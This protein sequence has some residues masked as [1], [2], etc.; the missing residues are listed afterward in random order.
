MI[1]PSSLS[2]DYRTNYTPGVR[3]WVRTT[4][5]SWTRFGIRLR[6]RPTLKFLNWT[7][8]VE[9]WTL[10]V[11]FYF[12]LRDIPCSNE[13]PDQSA[14]GVFCSGGAAHGA[15]D[16]DATPK[17][18]R[19]GRG[20]WRGRHGEH[21]RRAN[22]ERVGEFHDLAGWH[23]LRPHVWVVGFVC[24]SG[25]RRGERVPAR[26][27]ETASCSSYLSRRGNTS[28]FARFFSSEFANSGVSCFFSGAS[29]ATNSDAVKPA[30]AKANKKDGCPVV[31][32]SRGSLE[33]AAPGGLAEK[34][35]ELLLLRHTPVTIGF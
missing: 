25:H 32:F 4:L 23:C 30:F 15:R 3:N 19:L 10:G 27:D 29:G 31:L 9:R 13:P 2:I 20:S 8:G 28:D 11:C 34:F 1:N 17:E 6:K 35:A 33:T 7:L 16:L 26:A 21:F 14:V 12:G 18:R 5:L 24:A 22:V